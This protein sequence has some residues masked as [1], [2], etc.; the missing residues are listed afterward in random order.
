MYN[1]ILEYLTHRGWNKAT[2]SWS[3]YDWAN[4]A[5]ATIVLAGFFPILFKNYWAKGLAASEISLLLGI[6]ASMSGILLILAAPVIGYLADVKAAKK[7]YLTVCMVISVAA[8]IAFTF[9]GEGFWQ[10]ALICYVL[11]VFMFMAGNVFY[12][13]M[14]IDITSPTYYNRISSTGYALGYLGGGIALILGVLPVWF[15]DAEQMQQI[16]GVFAGVGIWWLLFSIPLLLWVREKHKRQTSTFGFWKPLKLLRKQP[17]LAWFL[18]AY[19]LYIDAVD[20]IIRIAVHYGD[21][22]GFPV[23]DLLI[24]LLLVQIIAFPA[25]LIY[26]RLAE[27]FGAHS[28]ITVGILIYIVICLWGAFL[29]SQLSFYILVVL[30][31]LVQGGLQAQSRAFYADMVPSEHAAQF[32]GIYNMLGKFAVVLGP[33]LFGF[34]TYL[35]DNPRFGLMSLIVMLALGLIVFLTRVPRKLADTVTD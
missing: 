33:L 1:N 10:A 13:A 3:L 14:L 30:I 11:S 8:T 4:S 2:L 19:W 28:M 15:G 7:A 35:S 18:L 12:D 26:G 25:T 16:K 32:F 29:D 6:G 5:F 20:T 23:E 24:A 21:V 22:K 17:A 31:A 34:T 9:L 27:H